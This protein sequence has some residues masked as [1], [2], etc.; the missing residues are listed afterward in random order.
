MKFPLSW[1]TEF[2]PWPDSAPALADRFEMGGIGV[3]PTETAG[4]LDP[5]IRVG[6]IA[7]VEPHPQADRLTVCRV[8]VGNAEPVV[9]VSGAP[10]LRAGRLVPVALVGARLPGGTQ[11]EAT[12]LRGVLSAGMLCS[13]AELG[14]GDDASGVLVLDAGA[15]PGTPLADV[16]GV[17]DTVVEVEITANRGD[18]LSVL[19]LA[20]ELAALTGTRWRAPRV[21]LR[22]QGAP[23]AEVGHV[24]IAAPDR[25]PHYCGRVVRDVRVGSS[26]FWMRLR[27]R[28]AGV[29]PINNV[30]DATNYVMVERGQPLHA[31]D[32]ER[33]PEGRVVVRCAAAGERLVT[34]DGVERT[35]EADD[36]VIAGPRAAIAVAGVMGGQET[37]VTAA[38]RVLLI[39]SAFFAPAGVRRTSRRLGLGSQASYRF[40]R[41]V[42]P[43]GVGPACDLAAALCAR[44]GRGRVA[45][46]RLEAGTATGAA[47]SPVRL[48]PARVASL[49]GTAVPRREIARRLHSLGLA[50]RTGG[51]AILAEAPPHRGD[52]REEVDLVEEVARVGGYASIPTTLPSVPMTHG[53]EAAARSWIRR[54]RRLL[55]AE[56]LSEAVTL[57]FTDAE[58]NA[59]FPGF[60]GAGLRPIAV[61]NPLSSESGELRRSP[62]VG[63]LRALETNVDRGAEYVGLFEIGKGYGLDPGGRAREPRAVTIALHGAW[64]PAGVARIGAPLDFL[65]VKGIVENLLLGLGATSDRVRVTTTGD[66]AFLHPGKGAR[67]ALD[68][69]T[70]GVLGALHPRLVQMLDLAAEVWI[71]ELDFEEVAHYVPRPFALKPPPGLPA[72]TRDIAVVADE[73][74]QADAIREAVL[75]FGDPRIESARLFDC[76]RGAPIAAGRKSLAY[77]IA[78]RAA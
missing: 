71:A 16:P 49:L 78:Y 43:A 12:T 18:W 77:S 3:E 52:L 67:V 11:V 56:G 60:V 27:L 62:L 30:V 9:I 8:D 50:C 73:A 25:C 19:G 36:L 38:T 7:A 29:R 55:V 28:R 44:L 35:L 31:F 74:F 21:A 70:L 37:E 66:V 41:R 53:A 51:D 65:D 69:R 17:A 46:G 63:L 32:L 39:E 2:V 10:G 59:R 22:E 1:L 45:P 58:S 23:A 76:Y 48:R 42:D 13:E 68:G 24:E 26:P 14:L 20:R 57:A 47:T 34:L 61:R 15:A 4:R 5:A 54:I 40:E 75:A 64:P 33:I 72:V 6:R